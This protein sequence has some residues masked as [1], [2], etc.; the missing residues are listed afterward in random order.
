[1]NLELLLVF[2]EV[3]EVTTEENRFTLFMC[4]VVEKESFFQQQFV[5]DRTQRR[6]SDS[7]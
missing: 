3:N 5:C 1:M 6:D 4:C 7:D 2:K